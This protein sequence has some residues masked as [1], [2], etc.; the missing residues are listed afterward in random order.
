LIAISRIQSAL[1]AQSSLRESS[2]LDTIHLLL[3]KGAQ[4]RYHDQH[5]PAFQYDGIAMELV[6]DL[7]IALWQ[8]DCV[9]IVTDH[10]LYAWS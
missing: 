6:P 4:V 3:G 1:S 2:A 10:S 5:L 8:I 7:G 9:V